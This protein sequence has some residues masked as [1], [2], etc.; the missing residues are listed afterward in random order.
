MTSRDLHRSAHRE[1]V[2]AR[3]DGFLAGVLAAI[4]LLRAERYLDAAELLERAQIV[5]RPKGEGQG[6]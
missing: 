6:K 2:L 1:E 4:A 5:E 3:E